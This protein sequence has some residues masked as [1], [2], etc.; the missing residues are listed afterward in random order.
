MDFSSVVK[1][2]KQKLDP[3]NRFFIGNV[4]L[5]FTYFPTKIV[6]LDLHSDFTVHN[7]FRFDD[8]FTENPKFQ[9]SY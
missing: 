3:T 2:L 6:K 8:F 9:F 4:Q 7:S 5:F 1:W